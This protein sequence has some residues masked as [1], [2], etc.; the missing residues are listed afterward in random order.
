MDEGHNSPWLLAIA[1]GFALVAAAPRCVAA[2]DEDRHLSARLGQKIAQEDNLFR[3]PGGLDPSLFLGGGAEREDRVDTTSVAL[4]GR[5]QR[6]E[7]RVAFDADVASNRFT[8]NV[9]L[10]NVAGDGSLD[11]SWRLGGRWSGELGARRERS[12]A[13]FSNTDS[14]AKD[15]LDT[16]AYFGE[17]HLDV[18]PRWRALLRARSATTTHDSESR[19]NDDVDVRTAVAGL[20]YHTPRESRL[21][22]EFRE[23]RATYPQQALTAGAGATS[24]Y[25][26]H[27]A[28]MTFAYI[29]TSKVSLNANAGYAWRTYAFAERGD[30][31]GGVW[32]ATLQWLPTQ[33]VRVSFERSRD[34]KAY[35]DAES[36][37]F[38][39]TGSTLS[40][41]WTPI[42]KLG[43]SLRG[44]R[45]DQSY[46]GADVLGTPNRRD[47]PFIGSLVVAYTPRARAAFELAV[48]HET[49]DSTSPRFDYGAATAS[50]AGEI[51]F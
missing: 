48:R 11:W 33:T 39:A 47:A 3:L 25:S 20:E 45:E 44:S 5:W 22:W 13:G 15:L 24:D 34:L 4:A 21:G 6:G 2:E 18:G 49:R 32:S 36:D 10:D 14:L 7:Q 31:A 8:Q 41:T 9:Y 40:A 29:F 17:A 42:A 1:L 28:V 23:A 38:V 27:R 30:F 43:L 16:R 26:E 46:I 35:L 12:L 50:V 51:R 37:H 19:R